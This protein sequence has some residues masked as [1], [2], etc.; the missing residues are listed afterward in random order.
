MQL[1]AP[2]GL[3]DGGSARLK[4][5]EARVHAELTE[6]LAG[7]S[8]WPTVKEFKAAG[9]S[10]LLDALY[11][12]GDGKSYRAKF[13]LPL[14][15]RAH[16][17]WSEDRIERELSV[18][19]QGLTRWPTQEEWIQAG[20]RNLMAACYRFGGHPY[21]AERFGFAT[22]PPSLHARGTRQR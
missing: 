15:P 13:E 7:R 1:P 20:E 8:H 18:F 12:Y 5:T 2:A 4:W 19:L 10:G 14:A 6:F 11:K 22:R 21:W 17:P 9:R 3:P 16:Q